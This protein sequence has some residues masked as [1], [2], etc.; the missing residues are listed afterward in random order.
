MQKKKQ[1]W[2]SLKTGYKNVLIQQYIQLFYIYRNK[3][4]EAQ[5][6]RN[7]KYKGLSKYKAYT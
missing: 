5:G 7:T 3:I 2:V 6:N 1:I 4:H